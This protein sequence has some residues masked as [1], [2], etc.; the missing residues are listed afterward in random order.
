M[1]TVTHI[2]VFR[3]SYRLITIYFLFYKSFGL[4][5]PYTC[6]L[7][8]VSILLLLQ[9]F[10]QA[11]LLTNSKNIRKLACNAVRMDAPECIF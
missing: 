6:W 1:S 10:I 11:G 8:E 5:V 4:T 3:V 7:S 9:E 2:Y